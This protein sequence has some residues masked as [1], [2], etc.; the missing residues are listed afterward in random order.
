[1]FANWAEFARYAA[2]GPEHFN[3]VP[4]AT[5]GADAFGGFFAQADG[6]NA[7]NPL[8]RTDDFFFGLH[9]CASIKD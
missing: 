8:I 9:N 6:L 4:S 3:F 2:T 7:F 1:M 5:F